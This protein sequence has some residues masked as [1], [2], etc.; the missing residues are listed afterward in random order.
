MAAGFVW[1]LDDIQMLISG[2]VWVGWEN[3]EDLCICLINVMVQR[4]PPLASAYRLSSGSVE[5]VGGAR[6]L[7]GSNSFQSIPV[8]FPFNSFYQFQFSLKS[9]DSIQSV[10]IQL[11]QVK[12]IP[13][14]TLQFSWH[15][16]TISAPH[17]G[18]G[19]RS[20]QPDQLQMSIYSRSYNLY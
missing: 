5:G 8:Q 13:F 16:S 19:V 4:P 3:K 12:S 11:I 2:L 17:N 6:A 7:V 9:S 14:D 20:L 15:A 18:H 10:P 1:H